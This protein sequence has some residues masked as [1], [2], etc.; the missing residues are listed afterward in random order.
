[1]ARIKGV[2]VE[3]A[4]TDSGVHYEIVK[5]NLRS[6]SLYGVKIIKSSS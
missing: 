4:W 6:A 3:D 1:M 2:K 5:Y